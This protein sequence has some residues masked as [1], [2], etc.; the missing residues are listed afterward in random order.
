[1]RGTAASDPPPQYNRITL[2][3][4]QHSQAMTG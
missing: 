2:D 3:A 4:V 1:M